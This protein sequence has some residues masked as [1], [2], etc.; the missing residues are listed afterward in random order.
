MEPK[1]DSDG[2]PFNPGWKRFNNEILSLRTRPDA[3]PE[4]IVDRAAAEGVELIVD[5]RKAGA[6]TPSLAEDCERAGVH[7]VPAL[8]K[9]SGPGL[10]ADAAVRYAKLAMRHKTCFVVDDNSEELLR[11][12]SEQIPFTA[13]PL[14]A[15]PGADADL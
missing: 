1:H 12:V 6:Q 5:A 9:D 8:G 3:A 14:E 11:L 10:S 7:Y 4:P 15:E 13:T 2:H